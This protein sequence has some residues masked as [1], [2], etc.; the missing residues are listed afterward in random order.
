M[1][2][3]LVVCVKALPVP[4]TTTERERASERWRRRLRA[5]LS[6]QVAFEG[7]QVLHGLSQDRQLVELLSHGLSR[8][9][10]RD[11]GGQLLD[12]AVHLVPPPFLDLVV[13]FPADVKRTVKRGPQKPPLKAERPPRLHLKH[14]ILAC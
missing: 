2:G 5:S 6:G 1:E 3:L 14:F 8:L 10:G 7:F 4:A 13:R 12:E 9:T 11:H